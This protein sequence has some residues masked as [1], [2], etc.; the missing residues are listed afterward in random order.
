M[1]CT[2]KAKF[3]DYFISCNKLFVIALTMK[4]LLLF[5]PLLMSCHSERSREAAEAM[6]ITVAHPEVRTVT[7]SK[8]YPG[9]LKADKTVQLIARVSGTLVDCFYHPGSRVQ[10]GERLFLIDPST[11]EQQVAEAQASL[12]NAQATLAY[13]H[14]S[15]ERTQQA[16]MADAVAQIQVLQTQ[17]AYLEAAAQVAQAEAALN[18]AQISLGYCS[19]TAPYC[20][21]VSLNTYDTG[22]YIN[23]A[24]NPVLATLYKDDTLYVYFNVSENQYLKRQL[25]VTSEMQALNEIALCIPA[26]RDEQDRMLQ[27]SARARLEY[28]SPGVSRSTGTLQLRAMLPNTSG[29]LR[30]GMYVLA[31]LPYAVVERAIVVPDASIGHDQ[32]GTYLYTVDTQNRVVRQAVTAGQLIDDS[33]RLISAGLQPTDRYVVNAQLKVRAGMTVQP[34]I[35]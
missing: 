24:E 13:T 5:L 29:L 34:T 30:D 14:A 32:A 4:R 31:T 17:S 9:Y 28:T 25:N 11:Y 1:V 15:Y 12:H 33:L 27:Q 8:E 22:N 2:Q 6:P 10:P 21:H 26:F 20:G 7:L 19:I 23:A 18:L 16:A 35:K 3:R